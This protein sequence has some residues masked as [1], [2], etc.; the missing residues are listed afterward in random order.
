MRTHCYYVDVH[1]FDVISFVQ[2]LGRLGIR[3]EVSDEW[4]FIGPNEPDKKQWYR[5]FKVYTT[6]KVWMDI[7]RE[8]NI[9][10]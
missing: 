6:K 5:T 9:T 7:C 2:I 3:F 8:A 1:N 10:K 4:Y